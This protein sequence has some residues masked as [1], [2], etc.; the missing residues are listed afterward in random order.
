MHMS[1][2]LTFSIYIHNILLHTCSN[3]PGCTFLAIN[4]SLT[5]V[6]SSNH[7]G[8]PYPGVLHFS[9]KPIDLR[10]GCTGP[11]KPYGVNAA[12]FALKGHLVP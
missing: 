5:W 4:S 7:I 1:K 3:Y 10:I 8:A 11:S 9:H 6:S 12:T 2:K